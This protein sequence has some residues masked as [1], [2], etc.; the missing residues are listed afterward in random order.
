VERSEIDG[1]IDTNDL[2]AGQHIYLPLSRIGPKRIGAPRVECDEIRACR[3]GWDVIDFGPDAR[4]E[5]GP[6]VLTIR[7][8]HREIEANKPKVCCENSLRSR[9]GRS[10]GC[11]VTPASRKALSAARAAI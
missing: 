2:C 7:N 11:T 6:V 9:K 8:G 10:R 5:I 4:D 3:L 1:L